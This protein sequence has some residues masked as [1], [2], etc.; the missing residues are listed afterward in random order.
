MSKMNIYIY[1][2][3]IKSQCNLKIHNILPVAL[4]YEK[5]VK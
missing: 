4:L 3:A 2:I 5:K 1:K